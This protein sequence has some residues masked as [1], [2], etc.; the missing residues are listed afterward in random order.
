VKLI[1]IRHAEPAWPEGPSTDDVGLTE[2]GRLQAA[3]T[4]RELAQR[5]AQP[6]TIS[7]VL[8]SPAKRARETALILAGELSQDV[9]VDARLDGISVPELRLKAQ[10]SP[11]SEDLR[12]YA[13]DLQERAWTC[14]QE[15]IETTDPEAYVVGVS[16]D[17]TIASLVCRTLGIPIE[18][19]RRF[20]IDEA[21]IT[22][23]SFTPRRTLLAL[24]NETCHLNET[25]A[26][27]P[28][29]TDS[30]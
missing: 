10:E 30:P 22:I 11:V 28:F 20:R 21:S 13:L 19:M 5:F 7:Q 16:H 29:T 8:S 23:L 27:A 1:L 9:S 18:D 25:I 15:L 26:Q 17:V 14:V 6:G 2:R 3:H 24:L 12:F 4:G